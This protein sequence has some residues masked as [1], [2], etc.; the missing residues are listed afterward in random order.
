MMYLCRH[1]LNFMVFALFMVG[2]ASSSGFDKRRALDLIIA[3]EKEAVCRNATIARNLSII[4]EL[5]SVDLR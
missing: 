4:Q 1:P 5:T 2:V 3:L